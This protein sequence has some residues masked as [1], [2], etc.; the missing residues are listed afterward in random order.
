MQRLAIFSIIVA[1]VASTGC[2]LDEFSRNPG[3]FR[4]K[5]VDVPDVSLES[6]ELS[7]RV[8]ALGHELMTQNP[9][10]GVNP[11]FSVVGHKELEIYHPDQ[12]G[13]MI[14]EGLVE[15]CKSDQELSAVLATELAKMSAEARASKRM[16]IAE[17][18]PMLAD[19][20]AATPGGN[21]DPNQLTAQAIFDK[22]LTQST[23]GKS[24]TIEDPDKIAASILQS[25]G[26]DVATLQKVAPLLEESKRKSAT[27]KQLGARGDAPKWSQ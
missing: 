8:D 2:T 26:I 18:L 23:R 15:R 1:I 4:N 6:R 3:G 25:A 7:A 24:K 12:N 13:V 27:G 11:T 14:S 21:A 17:P 10:L 20:G 9:F 5:P 19:A 16:R 22:Q